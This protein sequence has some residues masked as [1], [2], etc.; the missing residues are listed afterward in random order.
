M[1]PDLLNK[2]L[3]RYPTATTWDRFHLR[4][5][6]RRCP[7]ETL[8]EFFPARGKVLDIG[9]G[10]GHLGW[11]LRE[12]RPGLE[13]FG[14]DIDARKIALGQAGMDSDPGGAL[15]L[16]AGDA[17][18]WSELPFDFSTVVLFDVLYLLPF[19]LQE[20]VLGFAL[21][22]LAQ[23]RDAAI[24]LKILPPL[25]GWER[26]RTQVQEG[27]MVR[28]GKTRASGALTPS[29]DPKVYSDWAIRHGLRAEIFPLKTTPAS[30]LVTLK[31][32][33]EP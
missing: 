22:R 30:L 11:F 21:N 5:R 7:Y 19:T 12:T 9:C 28:L 4:Q 26:W 15:H 24:L 10:F 23:N 14:S 29:Q 17:K 25:R 20:E 33:Q 18:D 6:L 2:I 8:L 27:L 1:R 3:S 13:Y 32:T 16:F 31:R